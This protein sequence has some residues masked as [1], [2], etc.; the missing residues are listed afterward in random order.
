MLMTILLN[1]CVLHTLG[2]KVMV[3]LKSGLGG[4]VVVG[5]VG[6]RVVGGGPGGTE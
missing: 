5:D 2:S 1:I 6:G 3:T 4:G